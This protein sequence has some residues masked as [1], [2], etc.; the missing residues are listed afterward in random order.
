MIDNMGKLDTL[1]SKLNELFSVL[2]KFN[3]LSPLGM[4]GQVYTLVISSNFEQIAESIGNITSQL[5]GVIGS[6][7][8]IASNI[9]PITDLIK[10]AN[11]LDGTKV[12]SYKQFSESTVKVIN[13]A[14]QSKG[15]ETVQTLNAMKEMIAELTKQISMNS[16]NNEGVKI[17]GKL[18][19]EGDVG[20]LEGK[21]VKKISHKL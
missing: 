9:A 18:K 11:S 10:S 12:E 8:S 21:E 15:G 19:I 1:I 5:G 2:E 17:S 13:A 20:T 14:N 7:S 6:A 4:L 3:Y 16:N